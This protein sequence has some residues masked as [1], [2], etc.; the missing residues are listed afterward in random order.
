M[1]AYARDAGVLQMGGVRVAAAA[2]SLL[3]LAVVGAAARPALAAD[4]AAGEAVFRGTCAGCHEGQVPRAPHRVFLARLNARNVVSALEP[5]GLMAAQGAT[6]DDAQRRAVALFL[7]GK[8]AALEARSPEPPPCAGTAAHPDPSQASVAVG[9]GRD[10]SRFVPADI[11]GLSAAQLPRLELR[12]AFAYPDANRARGQPAIAHGAIY[13]GGQDG[14]VRALDLASGCVRW[15]FRASA[16]VRTGLVLGDAEH[17]GD[18]AGLYFGDIIGNAYALDARSGA[19]RWRVHVDD[20]PHVTLTGT[21]ALHRGV[22]YV[23]VSSLELVSA[24]DP[25]YA[26]CSFQGAVLA[27]EARTGRPLWKTRTIPR[28]PRK[29]G[30]TRV[31]TPIL[32]PSGA[33]VWNSPTVDARRGLLYVGTGENYTAPASRTSDGVLALRL[34]DGHPAWSFQA[35]ADDTYNLGC[36]V[37]D[38]ANCPPRPGPDYDIGASVIRLPLAGG[39]ELLFAGQKSGWVY[40]LDPQRR[41]RLVWKARLG[42]GGLKGGVH[43]GMASDGERLYVPI[44]DAPHPYDKAPRPGIARPGLHALD[45]ASGR[46]LWEAAAPQRCAGRPGCDPGISAAVTA[47]PGAVITDHSDGWVRIYAA[48]DGALLWEFDTTREFVTVSGE[49]AHGGSMGGGGA[50]VRDGYV[51]LNSGYT[52]PH[53]PG[54]LLLVFGIGHPAAG[55]GQET[56]MER[57]P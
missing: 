42:R 11:A 52:A 47:I 44:F 10:N 7:T 28:P 13:A 3:L 18:D 19:L 25:R 41:G 12:W 30:V 31:G 5:G 46:E 23:P 53:M 48:T 56:S 8:D 50:A 20:H 40:A 45:P 32:A 43:F 14:T 39:R 4:A 21:P 24:A 33:P 26:C 16:E 51:V 6:L 55:A 36:T 15:T 35:L 37:A 22:L 54:N 38:D 17:D 9:W 1:F 49:R 34:R 57:Q 29:V 2:P 27:L